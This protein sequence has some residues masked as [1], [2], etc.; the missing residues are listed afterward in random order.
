MKV[1]FMGTPEF[2]LSALK[3]IA[4]KHDVICVYTREPQI[5]GRGNKLTK[6]PVHQ[7]SE[8][9]GIL[10]RTPKTLRSPEAQKE[11][12]DLRADIAVVAAY[13]L[14][15]PQPI[16]EAF[17]KG[18]INIHGSLLPRWRGAAPIQR[19]IEAGDDKSGITI[20]NIVQALDAGDML[21]KGEV[22]I[23]KETTGEILHDQ[24]AELGAELIVQALNQID[25]LQSKAEKQN[26]SLV[27][28]A[29]KIDKKESLIDFNLSAEELERKIRAFNPYPAMYFEYKGERIKILKA[30]IC[31]QNGK[32]GMILEGEQALIIACGKEALSVQELQRAGKKKMTIKEVLNGFKFENI[33]LS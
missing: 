23:T 11:Y 15:L 20:M 1:V 21:L 9:N 18:C 8:E 33:V 16:I 31:H 13:G 32:A 26:E 27:T 12:A 24:L 19:A 25:E 10:V 6:S 29:A 2:A 5:A 14:I 28:Y 17:P 4:K 3:K 30:E 7:W 22:K